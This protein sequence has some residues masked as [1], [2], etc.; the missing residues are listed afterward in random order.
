[1]HADKERRGG[2]PRLALGAVRGAGSQLGRAVGPF[3]DKGVKG[4]GDCK[5]VQI[6]SLHQILGWYLHLNCFLQGDELRS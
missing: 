3:D 4:Q 6:N 1:M 2:N 5:E